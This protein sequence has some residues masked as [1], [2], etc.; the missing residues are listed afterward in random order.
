MEKPND[1]RS[2][3]NG[4]AMIAEALRDVMPDGQGGQSL[5][6]M[7]K[8]HQKMSEVKKRQLRKAEMK[9]LR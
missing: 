8:P 5:L 6:S 4:S 3:E 1:K 7:V 2:F 9:R